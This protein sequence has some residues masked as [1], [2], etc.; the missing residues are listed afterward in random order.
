MVVTLMQ[1]HAKKHYGD[2]ELLARP[3]DAVLGQCIIVEKQQHAQANQLRN[4][5]PGPLNL[6]IQVSH[7]VSGSNS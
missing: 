7:R 1:E 6:L 5:H 2:N 4:A 3:S